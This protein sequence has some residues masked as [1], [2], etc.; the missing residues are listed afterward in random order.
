[1]DATLARPDRQARLRT[2]ALAAAEEIAAVVGRLDPPEH[3]VVRGP[4]TGLVMVRGRIG[5]GSAPFNAGEATVS[6]CVVRLASGEVGFGHVLGRDR[7]QARGVA[8]L[9]AMGEAPA[10]ARVVAAAV[11]ELE[12]ARIAR[13]AAQA[14]EVAATKVDFFTMTRGED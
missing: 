9:D 7:A 1:M 10:S 4:E 8:L 2:L 13:E 14:A 12:A 5:G 3:A 11:A 6:R